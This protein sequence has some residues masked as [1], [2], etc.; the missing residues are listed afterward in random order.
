MNLRTSNWSASGRLID[1]EAAMGV[2]FE[3][4]HGEACGYPEEAAMPCG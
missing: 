3:R 4:Q 2:V 1:L